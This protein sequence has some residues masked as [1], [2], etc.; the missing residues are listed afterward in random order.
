[1][2]IGMLWHD[3]GPHSLNDKISRAVAFYTEK[4]GH[5]PTLCM[6]NPDTL[7]GGERKLG[8]VE[9]RQTRSVL[10]NHLWIGIDEKPRRARRVS[11]KAA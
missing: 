6:V 1:M 10:R 11:Q 2:E 7:N 5:K 9:V 3:D 4:Y 8:G